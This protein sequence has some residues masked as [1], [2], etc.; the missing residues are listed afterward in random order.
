VRH[1]RLFCACTAL[2]VVASAQASR[3]AGRPQTSSPRAARLFYESMLGGVDKLDGQ[4]LL[5]FVAG[6]F[7]THIDGTRDVK[8]AVRK[9]VTATLDLS[10]SG[11]SLRRAKLRF[12]S[13]TFLVL[14][15]AATSDARDKSYELS[16]IDFDNHGNPEAF[17]DRSGTDVIRQLLWATNVFKHLALP[18]EPVKLLTGTIF[19]GASKEPRLPRA[20]RLPDDPPGEGLSGS[21]RAQATIQLARP[22][23]ASTCG[24]VITLDSTGSIELRSLT[25]VRGNADDISG[26]FRSG[27]LRL[28]GGCMTAEG[29]D[30]QIRSGTTLKFDRIRFRSPDGPRGSSIQASG[31][32]LAGRGWRSA[33]VMRSPNLI[34]IAG[35]DDTSLSDSSGFSDLRSFR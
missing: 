22:S 24:S 28:S 15:S 25:L 29:T 12:P 11:A 23:G 9:N 31:G 10:Y 21:L 34:V 17:F 4:I 19:S 3:I 18:V 27:L 16:E 6:N 1:I 35:S 32:A 14:V 20:L 30:I 2:A 13:D 5:D 8:W 26:E 33:G 7:S